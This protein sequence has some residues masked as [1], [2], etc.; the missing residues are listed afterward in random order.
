MLPK[1]GNPAICNTMNGPCGHYAKWNKSKTNII[2]SHLCVESKNKYQ[3]KKK[4]REIRFLWL[5]ET[6]V[7]EGELDEG[8]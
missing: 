1:K 6:A 4:E 7:E 2:W 8:G 5:P 3:K